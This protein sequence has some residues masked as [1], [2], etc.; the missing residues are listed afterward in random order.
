[1]KYSELKHI[2][3]ESVLESLNENTPEQNRDYL[4]GQKW[5][6]ADKQKG[7]EH[8][9]ISEQTKEFQKGYYSVM[10]GWWDRFN[11]K[12]TNFAANFGFGNQKR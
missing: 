2:I 7:I 11:H 8:R 12:L 9:D 3:A 4:R 6:I 10:G 1:M 5:A